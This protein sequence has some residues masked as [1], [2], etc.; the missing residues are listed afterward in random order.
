MSVGAVPGPFDCWL[1][2]R[3]LKTLA[4]RMEAHN[5]NAMTIAKILEDSQ[6]I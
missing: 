6:K 2:Q 1:T 5:Y 4:I 3:S